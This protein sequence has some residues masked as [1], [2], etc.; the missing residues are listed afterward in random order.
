MERCLDSFDDLSSEKETNGKWSS[1]T[2]AFG[3][4]NTI[5]EI[6]VVEKLLMTTTDYS[7]VVIDQVQNDIRETT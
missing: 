6:P 2:V 3:A 1:I 7:F 4:T 5:G